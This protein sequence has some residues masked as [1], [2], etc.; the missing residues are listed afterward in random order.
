VI[1]RFRFL[2]CEVVV[3]GATAT[4]LEAVQRLFAEREPVFDRS[5]DRS[6]LG[7]LNAARSD[8]VVASPLLA[9]TLRIALSAAR[10]TDGLVAPTAGAD[11]RRV[12]VTPSVIGRRP[13][14]MLD[15][16]RVAR[17]LAADEALGLLRGAGFVSAGGGL[18]ARGAVVAGLPGGGTIRV[19]DS[20]LAT[21]CGG[22]GPW[23]HV[24]ASGRSCLAATVAARA[25]LVLGADGP[26]WLDERSLPGRF[27]G[28]DGE[29]VENRRWLEALAAPA[30]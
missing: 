29:V 16:T 30:A 7:R 24:T 20:A 25:A 19:V 15:L 21:S 17:A 6:E 11:W 8:L 14:V 22:D 27:V 3:G 5:D 12:H 2:G 26:Q 10:Q 4:E 23:T 18:S 13:G 28:E 1:R 9:R